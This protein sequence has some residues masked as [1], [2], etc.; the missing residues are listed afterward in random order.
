MVGGAVSTT[1]TVAWHV[2]ALPAASAALKVTAVLP[3]W[4]V[5]GASCMICRWLVQASVAEAPAKKETS[6]ASPEGAPASDTHSTV[7]GAGQVSTGGSPSLLAGSSGFDPHP[8][9]ASSG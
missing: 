7:A 3:R 1:V 9:S 4:K 2:D 5:A 8:S 6:C